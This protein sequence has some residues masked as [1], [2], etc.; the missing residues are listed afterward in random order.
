MGCYINPRGTTKEAWL[1][2]HGV[3][4]NGPAPITESHV[5][6]CLVNNGPF[7]AAGVA[8]DSREVEAFNQPGDFRPKKWHVV[9]REAVRLVSDLANYER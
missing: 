8:F 1:R 9:S 4:T 7:N 6:V 3:P 5:P 2:E